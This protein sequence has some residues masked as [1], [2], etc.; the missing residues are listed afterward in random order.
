[1][2]FFNEALMQPTGRGERTSN[3]YDCQNFK[4]I[5]TSFPLTFEQVFVGVPKISNRV[6]REWTEV[7]VT[8]K[9]GQEN[10]PIWRSKYL[11]SDLLREQ[12]EAL[13]HF[14][15]LRPW[16]IFPGCIFP[17]V[18][19][20]EFFQ[21]CFNEPFS[22]RPWVR[23][24]TKLRAFLKQAIHSNCKILKTSTQEC[25]YPLIYTSCR[26]TVCTYICTHAHIKWV[27]DAECETRVRVL[28]AWLKQVIHS[29]ESC[30][31]WMSHVTHE[32]VISHMK[33]NKL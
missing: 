17:R 4:Q 27:C 33:H 19:F 11:K 6:P 16:C 12:N 7:S 30:H 31:I 9:S 18:H 28:K 8:Q 14:F 1:M 32:W 15:S 21:A 29:S 23:S 13:I 26:S 3:I 22:I 25:V 5:F 20:P 10:C 24:H 2:L